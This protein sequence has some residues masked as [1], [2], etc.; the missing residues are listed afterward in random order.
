MG[1]RFWQQRDESGQLLPRFSTGLMGPACY[2]RLRQWFGLAENP[3][4][5]LRY[6]I[7]APMICLMA[8]SCMAA[9]GVPD[10]LAGSRWILTE[11]PP[12]ELLERAI[13]TLGFEDDRV[14]GSDGCNRFH[15]PFTFQ[16]DELRIGKLVSTRK[17]CPEPVMRQAKAYTTALSRARGVRVE[18]E[19]LVLLDANGELLARF[20]PQP[21]TLANTQ[22]KV[23]GYNNGKQAVVST[24]RDSVLTLEFDAGGAVHGT[25]GCNNFRGN[26][27]AGAAEL[28]IGEIAS[29]RRM[30]EE[31]IMAQESA[32]LEALRRSATWR[33]EANRLEV[34]DSGHALLVIAT[35]AE[36]GSSEN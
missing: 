32:Y 20:D 21:T 34:R 22:W 16:D 11:L 1:T 28:T 18:D 19:S 3:M 33:A 35:L 14:V 29:T 27:S 8:V 24:E 36:S 9:T 23:T 4:H 17:A 25:A 12:D 31:Q 6:A 30:C 7:I 2:G 5:T 26:Y 15:G 10:S 13:A